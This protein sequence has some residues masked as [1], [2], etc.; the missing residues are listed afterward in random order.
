MK[1]LNENINFHEK[2]IELLIER[3]IKNSWKFFFLKNIRFLY[4][5]MIFKSSLLMLETA[6]SVILSMPIL[7]R[8]SW[9]I[10]S[11]MRG[12]LG[13]YF[14]ALCIRRK[15]KYMG[16]GVLIGQNVIIENFKRCSFGSLSYIDT[17][18]RVMAEVCIG[19][20][21]HLAQGVLISGGGKLS[22]MDFAS[23]GMRSIVLTASDMPAGGFRA[24]GPMV[25]IA[26]R[27]VSSKH[28]VLEVDA[29]VGPL[30]VLMPGVKMR[31]GSVLAVSSTL[32]RSTKPWGV[33]TGSPAE[34][35]NYR[36]EI[37]K[38]S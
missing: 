19:E 24:S 25:P 29:F 32:R 27:N 17:D 31:E 4:S 15:L 14:R 2:F 5:S 13:Y 28:T 38:I 20:R 6:V 23:I 7:S 22:V 11:N 1:L 33:Y 30:C 34:L 8:L 26:E 37:D 10:F 12:F 3:Q 18:C 35:I 36:Q 16:S 9:S 21:C